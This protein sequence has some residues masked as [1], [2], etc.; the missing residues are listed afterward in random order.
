MAITKQCFFEGIK[1]AKEGIKYM[2]KN[3]NVFDIVDFVADCGF[4]FMGF[5]AGKLIKNN[6]H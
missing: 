2:A 3:G 4:R 5:R 6:T 1:Y